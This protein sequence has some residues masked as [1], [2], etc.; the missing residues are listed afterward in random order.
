MYTYTRKCFNNYGV[1]TPKLLLKEQY[2]KWNSYFL[3]L[4]YIS[5]KKNE[6]HIFGYRDGFRNENAFFL[7]YRKM[8]KR[9]NK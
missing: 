7:L 2:V 6:Q 3:F 8:V 4:G 5:Q 1:K 9:I